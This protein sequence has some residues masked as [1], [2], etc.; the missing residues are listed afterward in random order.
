M[1]WSAAPGGAVAPERRSRERPRSRRIGEAGIA[2]RAQGRLGRKRSSR[3][4]N[5]LGVADS[6]GLVALRAKSEEKAFSAK[7]I[8][9][10]VAGAP[11]DERDVSRSDWKTASLWSRLAARLSCVGGSFGANKRT[12]GEPGAVWRHFALGHPFSPTAVYGSSPT[13]TYCLSPIAIYGLTAH[14]R[15]SGSPPTSMWPATLS[16][17]RSITVT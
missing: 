17:F 11:L 3:R 9:H 2:A 6:L 4:G 16:V 8:V 12:S 14:A 1:V 13:A 7:R 15:P 10:A 5:R